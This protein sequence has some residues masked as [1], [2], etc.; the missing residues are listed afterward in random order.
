MNDDICKQ[1]AWQF[2][3]VFMSSEFFPLAVLSWVGPIVS[4]VS[5]SSASGMFSWHLFGVKFSIMGC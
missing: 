4:D 1:R 3:Y 2:I 5:P